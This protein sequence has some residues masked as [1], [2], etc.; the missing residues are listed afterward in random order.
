MPKQIYLTLSPEE[1]E[2]VR[3]ALA[4]RFFFCRKTMIGLMEDNQNGA[5]PNADYEAEAAQEYVGML[6]RLGQRLTYLARD[7]DL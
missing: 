7:N 1:L 3:I 5:Y 6:S 2:A 4:S